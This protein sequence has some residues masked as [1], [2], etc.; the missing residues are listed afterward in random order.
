[1]TARRPTEDT[2]G[3]LGPSDFFSGAELG[4]CAYAL[5]MRSAHVSAATII[6]MNQ[7]SLKTRRSARNSCFEIAAITIAC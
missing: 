6:S 4:D 2:A 3:Y 1:V 5:L 7:E